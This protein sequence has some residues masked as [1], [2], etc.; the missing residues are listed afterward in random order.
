MLNAF[1]QAKLFIM[2]LSPA[3]L[4]IILD[5]SH[6]KVLLVQRQDVPVWVLP[7]GG[8][9]PKETPEQAALRE[10]KEETGYQV[11]IERQTAH[12]LPINALASVTSVFLCHVNEGSPTLS[13]EIRAIQFFPLTQLPKTLFLPHQQWIKEGLASPSLIY[14]D[15]T[16]VS[17][18][19]VFKICL[20]HPWWTLRYLWTR[21]TK[22]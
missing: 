11:T 20:R 5:V 17:Y 16:E 21:L 22:K 1:C 12:Y 14:R 7:G 15:L 6:T 10:I 9:E 18:A 13:S 2:P 3:S 4:G 19:T 8:I